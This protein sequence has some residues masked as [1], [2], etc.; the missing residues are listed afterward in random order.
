MR[1]NRMHGSRRRGLETEH[2][3]RPRTL[4]WDSCPGNRRQQGPRSYRRA[5]T[6]PIPDPTRGHTMGVIMPLARSRH[7]VHDQGR[8]PTAIRSYRMENRDIPCRPAQT[9]LDIR[10]QAPRCPTSSIEI[11]SCGHRRPQW[12][13]GRSRVIRRSVRWRERPGQRPGAGCSEPPA[14]AIV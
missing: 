6:A 12:T 3:A 2:Q 13:N 1:E 14:S 11:V 7:R 4:G 9:M 8:V 5:A 10:H